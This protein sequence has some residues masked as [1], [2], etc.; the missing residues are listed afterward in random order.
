MLFQNI[1]QS[2][3]KRL[4]KEIIEDQI[5]APYANCWTK[6]IK[7]ICDKYELSIEEVREWNKATLKKEIKKRINEHIG[8]ELEEKKREMK[9]LRFIDP[10]NKVNYTREMKTA[11]AI[12]IMKTRL[13]MLELKANFRGKYDNMMCELCNKEEDSTE[14]LFNCC[15]MKRLIGMEMG[16]E[17]LENPD[18]K[19]IEYLKH[20]MMIKEC[21]GLKSVGLGTK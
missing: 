18:K 6:S 13:N 20:A 21:V 9:K 17:K 4:I 2:D 7:E 10:L 11:D 14:H 19:L 3:E 5:R 1:V 16:I 12:L 8:K 15:K